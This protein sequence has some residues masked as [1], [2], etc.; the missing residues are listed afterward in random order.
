M[1]AMKNKTAAATAEPDSTLTN[2]AGSRRSGRSGRNMNNAGSSD[3]APTLN[4]AAVRTATAIPANV[5]R[6]KMS[7]AASG[8]VRRPA[9][10]HKNSKKQVN[11]V[12]AHSA[13]TGFGK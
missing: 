11:A 13:A 5:S 6:D 9:T 2:K 1:D 12:N 3:N 7:N 10:E 8:G 4:P